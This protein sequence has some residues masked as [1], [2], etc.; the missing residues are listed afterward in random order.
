[1]K[2]QF[3]DLTEDELMQLLAASDISA[4]EAL[5]QLHAVNVYRYAVRML[6]NPTEADDIVQDV[7]LKIWN[8]REKYVPASHFR[9]W[10]LRICANLCIDRQR[11][12]D[13]RNLELSSADA[14][15]ANEEHSPEDVALYHELLAKACQAFQTLSYDDQQILAMR[16]DGDL[17]VPETAEAMGCSIRTVYY[18]TAQAIGRLQ[19]ASGGCDE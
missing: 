14:V 17:S 16:F 13:N 7:F 15:Q 3:Q 8:Y 4:L 1:M 9:A 11:R 2:K 10:A 6:G 5:Y 18:R 19:V 12:A